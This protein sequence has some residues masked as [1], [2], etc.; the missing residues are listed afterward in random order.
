[1]PTTKCSLR[2]RLGGLFPSL[3]GGRRKASGPPVLNRQM[4]KGLIGKI[5]SSREDEISCDECGEQLARFAELTLEGKDAAQ[6]I[7]LVE[8]H[9]KRCEECREEFEALL[10]ALSEAE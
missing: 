8:D 2:E 4:L 6:A 5:M 7:P 3:H 1:M 9:L 10:S